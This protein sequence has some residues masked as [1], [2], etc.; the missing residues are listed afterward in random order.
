MSNCSSC[1]SC[2]GC[3]GS[4]SLTEGELHILGTLSQIP[5]LPIYRK[6][7]DASPIYLEDDRLTTEEYSLVLQHLEVKRL[8][9]LDFDQPLKNA[10]PGPYPIQG[11]MAL[12]ARG[13]FI[14]DLLD[15]QGLEES[16]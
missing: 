7:D 12:T 16:E 9:S 6:I 4:L 5:F 10:A 2:S 14:L 8:I 1:S 11:S 13:Q 3:S 15:R